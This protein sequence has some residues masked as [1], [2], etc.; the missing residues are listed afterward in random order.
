MPIVHSHALPQ[1]AWKSGNI[2]RKVDLWDYSGD[3]GTK[4]TVATNLDRAGGG[5]QLVTDGTDNDCETLYYGGESVDPTT[6]GKRFGFRSLI[7]VVE[8]NTED[9]DWYVGFS[10]VVG[11]TFFSDT[12]TLASMDAFG[13]Y[14]VAD[15]MFFR[16]C[17]LNATTQNGATTTTAFA[18]A[19]EYLLEMVCEVGTLGVTSR[20]YVNGDQIGSTIENS[21]LTGLGLMHPI[22]ALSGSSANAETIQVI[23]YE[24]WTI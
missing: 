1:N 6:A 13:I 22:I 18:S 14:K 11:A 2:A 8:G 17:D 4:G 24:F 23:N 20:Y 9:S 19:T 21:S 10:D 7:N 5:I 3:N 16:T 12:D 15:S